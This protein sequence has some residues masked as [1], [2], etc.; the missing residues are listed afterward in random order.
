[1]TNQRDLIINQNC[2]II[3][4]NESCDLNN[5][6]WSLSLVVMGSN[7]TNIYIYIYNTVCLS[8]LIYYL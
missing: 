6:I 1:M 3:S 7:I 4:P 5:T 2:I 8:V